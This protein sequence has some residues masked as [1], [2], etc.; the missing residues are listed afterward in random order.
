MVKASAV[1][2]VF[3][4]MKISGLLEAWNNSMGLQRCCAPLRLTTQ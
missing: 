1:T 2:S 4:F 3:V